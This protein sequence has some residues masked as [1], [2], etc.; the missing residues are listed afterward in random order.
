MLKP[1]Y[2]AGDR[3]SN[4]NAIPQTELQLNSAMRGLFIQVLSLSLV[5]IVPYLGSVYGYRISVM[6][7]CMLQALVAIGF[8]L[9]FSTEM[10]WHYIHGLF[11]ILV[12]VMLAYP[13]S[14]GYYL[15]AFMLST[16]VYWTTFRSQV[17]YYPSHQDVAASLQNI[18]SNRGLV[19]SPQGQV[20]MI[21]IGSGLGGVMMQLSI[22]FPQSTFSGI[23][24][25]PLPWAL[26]VIKSRLSN[27][28]AVFQY[29]DY[30]KLNFADYDVV[31]A[32]LSPA[33]M[34]AVWQKARTEMTPGSLLISNEF[35]V[36]EHPAY[37]TVQ[38]TPQSS[39]L[40]V[41]RM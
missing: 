30:H 34:H 1:E 14:P 36:P 29:G 32:Y 8:S 33:V 35:N 6:E 7:V 13:I 27:T 41:W 20:R 39:R 25:A 28:R 38:L 10:W 23:E 16:A 5:S 22:I 3:Q 19:I 24:I 17:P 21:D 31:Y 15:V 11:P 18:I 26:S 9:I 4:V 12:G 37:L 40:Y 2:P